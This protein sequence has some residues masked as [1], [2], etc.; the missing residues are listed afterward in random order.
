MR[1]VAQLVEVGAA[2]RI[3]NRTFADG[4]AL[5]RASGTPSTASTTS[6]NPL[7]ALYQKECF[8]A[9]P[10]TRRRTSARYQ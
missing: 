2:K 10:A 8:N 7:I 1:R 9:P 5:D 3:A 6:A 4:G